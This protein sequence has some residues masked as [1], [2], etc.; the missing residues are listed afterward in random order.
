MIGAGRKNKLIKI[1]SVVNTT[2][3]EGEVTESL[4]T[5]AEV[6]G[7][8]EPLTAKEQWLAKQSQATTTHKITIWYQ[9]NITSRMRAEWNGRVFHFN[10]VVCWHEENRELVIDATEQTE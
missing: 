5:F 4:S 10:G 3:N 6:Y 2:T 1:L 7:A 8:I 9:L